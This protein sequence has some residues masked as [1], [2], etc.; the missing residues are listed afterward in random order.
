MA[1]NYDCKVTFASG[2]MITSIR[3]YTDRELQEF[4][5]VVWHKTYFE[6]ADVKRV[7]SLGIATVAD[8]DDHWI[9]NRE[10]SLYKEYTK[11]GLSAKLHQ[12]MINVDYVTCATKRLADAIFPHNSDVEVLPNAI[13]T[14]Y[15]G[16]TV[17][18]TKE[19]KF[20][21]GYLGGPCHIRDL[22]LLKGLQKEMTEKLKDYDLRLFG[23]NGTDIY[24]HYAGILSDDRNSPN[25]SLYKGADIFHYPQFYNLMDCSLVPLESNYFN[26]MKSE[27]KLI[28]AGHFKKACIVSNVMPYTN[29]IKHK[30]NCL[31]VYTPS[32][33]FKN[34]KLLLENKNLAVDLGE[35]LYEDTQIYSI[36]KVNHLRFKFLSRCTTK[37]HSLQPVM[38]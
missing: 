28:E 31:V 21:F 27:L 4:D 25:F 18:R 6:L 32:D 12:L 2:L 7:R 15:D 16:F 17:N 35:Q 37:Q 33:W 13:D 10:H 11:D 34:A 5:V 23:F 29:I 14:G 26:S 38:T 8:F 36:A 3:A 20:I 22:G 24:K 19:D 30:K 9:V 1:K